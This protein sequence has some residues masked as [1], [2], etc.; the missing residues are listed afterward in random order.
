M[1][2]FSLSGY[3]FIKFLQSG[4]IMQDS[5]LDCQLYALQILIFTFHFMIIINIFEGGLLCT[6]D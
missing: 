4:G 2:L 6:G 5:E 1:A 3:S